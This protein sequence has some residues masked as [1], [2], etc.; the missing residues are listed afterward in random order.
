MSDYYTL[1]VLNPFAARENLQKP[2]N[3]TCVP[4]G[5]VR[6]YEHE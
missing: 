2:K 6:E 1:D 4:G 5:S 3:L